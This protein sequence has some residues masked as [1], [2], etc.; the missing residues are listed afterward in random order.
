MDGCGRG[1]QLLEQ[2]DNLG[3][4]RGAAGQDGLSEMPLADAFVDVQMSSSA[5]PTQLS[6]LDRLSQPT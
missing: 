5:F 6:L 4:V 1:E 3:D 2:L